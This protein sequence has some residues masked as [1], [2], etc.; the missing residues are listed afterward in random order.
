MA[1]KPA[2][3]QPAA[4]SQDIAR[5]RDILIGPLMRD[6]DQ[7]FQLVQRDVERL[8]KLLDQ[9]TEQLHQQADSQTQSLDCQVERLSGQ[10]TEQ[11]QRLAGKAADESAKIQSRFE[12][13]ASRLEQQGSAQALKLSQEAERRDKQLAALD[14]TIAK[15]FQTL[16]RETRAGDDELRR[17]LREMVEKLTYDKADRQ[18]LG[19]MLVEIGDQLIRGGGA[20]SLDDLL[21]SL[22]AAAE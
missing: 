2:S 20:V 7:R 21:T 4:G 12:E 8:Q 5:V 6:Y 14:A 15:K 9:M 10:L 19:Q 17:E 3:V 18:S 1:A 11:D 13:L 22:P 16:Q